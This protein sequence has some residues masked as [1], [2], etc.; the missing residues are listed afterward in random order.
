VYTPRSKSKIMLVPLSGAEP[1]LLAGG[2][3]TPRPFFLIPFY[4]C[5]FLEKKMLIL[6]KIKI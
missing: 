5:I 2:Q 1:M 6:K 4:L 3:L